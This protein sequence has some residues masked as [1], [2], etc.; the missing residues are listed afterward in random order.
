M[1]NVQEYKEVLFNE[2]RIY[3]IEIIAKKELNE[4]SMIKAMTVRE[5][6]STGLGIGLT[7]ADVIKLAKN[8]DIDNLKMNFKRQ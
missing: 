5:N 3:P 1:K 6:L 7:P 8:N 4:E 2:M